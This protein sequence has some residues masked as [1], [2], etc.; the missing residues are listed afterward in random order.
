MLVYAYT[1]IC[2]CVGIRVCVR[3]HVWVLCMYLCLYVCDGCVLQYF[4]P[5]WWDPNPASGDPDPIQIR[6]RC[7]PDT[8]AIRRPIHGMIRK[9][10]P[11]R[12]VKTRWWFGSKIVSFHVSVCFCLISLFIVVNMYLFYQCD[13]LM[14]FTS[15]ITC[16]TSWGISDCLPYLY[17]WYELISVSF[18]VLVVYH[19]WLRPSIG[20]P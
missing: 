12:A 15:V 17:T 3:M 1:C 10:I 13:Y 5:V 8:M 11:V 6:A 4:R 9:S 14:Y 18:H 19:C 20:R 7:G 16:I 2:M